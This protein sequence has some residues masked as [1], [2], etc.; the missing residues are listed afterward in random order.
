M[1]DSASRGEEDDSPCVGKCILVFFVTLAAVCVVVIV[2]V[3]MTICQAA[4]RIT[5]PGFAESSVEY[6]K[7]PTRI[8][9][10]RH[11]QAEH[12]VNPH[13]QTIDTLLTKEGETQAK[14]WSLFP[15]PAGATA[16]FYATS[17][18]ALKPE[19]AF[20]SPLRRAVQT[21]LVALE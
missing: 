5:I 17:P 20:I 8:Y 13:T 7:P 1:E 3:C 15:V 2:I 11:A 12:N 9:L 18:I 10:M 21:A 16:T 4:E 14:A 6:R 19:V